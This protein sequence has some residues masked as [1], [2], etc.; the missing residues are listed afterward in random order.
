V[1]DRAELIEI[2]IGGAGGALARTAAAVAL[3]RLLG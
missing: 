3:G 2:F 1:I